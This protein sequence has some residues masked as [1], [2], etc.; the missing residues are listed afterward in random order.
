M[1]LTNTTK[2]NNPAYH[3]TALAFANISV[4]SYETG[5]EC[6]NHQ[7]ES[8]LQ[9]YVHTLHPHATHAIPFAYHFEHYTNPMV[10]PVTGETISSYKKLMH[11]PA[12]AEIW[13]TAFGKDFRG[14]SQ[15]NN[16]TSQKGTNAMFV[17]THEE[18]QHVL[19]A[20]KKVIYANPVVDH[21]SQKEDANHFPSPLKEIGSTMMRN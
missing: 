10:H 17:M 4:H 1:L 3:K 16:K 2:A 20:D 9:C 18:I 7:G 6:S 5:Y 15:C 8:N 14:M 12:T 11:D 13:Q 19:R 21:C